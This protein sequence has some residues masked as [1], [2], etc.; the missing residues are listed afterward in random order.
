MPLHSLRHTAAASWL[1]TGHPLFFVQ[2]QLG[3]RSLTTTE[4]HYGHL[5]LSFVEGAAA[6]TEQGDHRSWTVRSALHVMPTST[7]EL[8][9]RGTPGGQA[10]SAVAR[11]AFGFTSALS[12][13]G[14]LRHR[15]GGMAT[16]RLR[17]TPPGRGR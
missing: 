1:T 8:A 15:G 12:A 13:V 10:E 6:R 5:E 4:R 17:S 11:V 9:I 7:A 2:R 3:H 14:S 16:F